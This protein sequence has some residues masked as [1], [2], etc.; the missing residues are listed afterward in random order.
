MTST[1]N[2]IRIVLTVVVILGCAY[3]IEKS[4]SSLAKPALTTSAHL[5]VAKAD[6]PII[7]DPCA[8]GGCSSK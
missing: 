3:Y 7:V 5:N 1:K 4:S 6:A 8:N 2:K